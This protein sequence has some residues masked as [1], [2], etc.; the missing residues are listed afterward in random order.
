MPKKPNNHQK[1]FACDF[2]P[3]RNSHVRLMNTARGKFLMC[4]ECVRAMAKIIEQE[5]IGAAQRTNKFEKPDPGAGADPPRGI[6]NNST[7]TET[8][9]P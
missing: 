2:C 6:G 8:S 9:A 7:Q 1:K 3:A 5:K 4:V